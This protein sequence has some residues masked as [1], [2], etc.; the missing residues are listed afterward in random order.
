[1]LNR[2]P[3]RRWSSWWV[4]QSSAAFEAPRSSSLPARAPL[5]TQLGSSAWVCSPSQGLGSAHSLNQLSSQ[6]PHQQNST[7]YKPSCASEKYFQAQGP[8]VCSVTLLLFIP[9]SMDAPG[10]PDTHT[11][12]SSLFLWLQ[13]HHSSEMTPTFLPGEVRAE[14][15]VFKIAGSEHYSFFGNCLEKMLN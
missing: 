9:R 6:P 10:L 4:L 8:E 1:M 12:S 15:Q 13:L 3:A 14:F 2:N 5:P 7:L 11:F